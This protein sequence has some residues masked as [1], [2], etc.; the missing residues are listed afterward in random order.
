MCACKANGILLTYA[1]ILCYLQISK[2]E[3]GN[4]WRFFFFFLTSQSPEE[5]WG[6]GKV[7]R[8]SQKGKMK[9]Y[10]SL[11]STGSLKPFRMSKI[12]M[13]TLDLIFH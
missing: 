9:R 6:L 1:H 13:N 2:N 3:T 10:R 7:Q 4:E 11:E 12:S 5:E 8:I